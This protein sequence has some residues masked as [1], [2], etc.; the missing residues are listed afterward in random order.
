[1]D[2][3]TPSNEATGLDSALR[4]ALSPPPLPTQFRARLLTRLANEPMSAEA[5]DAMRATLEQEWRRAQ[6]ALQAESVQ[7]RWQTL[8]WLIGGAFAAG[9]VTAAAMPWVAQHYGTQWSHWVP[10]GVAALGLGASGW[11]D[12]RVRRVLAQWGVPGA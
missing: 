9:A 11:A 2:L 6:R 8:L 7:L 12:P 3:K 4:Q 1:M 10:V 5:Y